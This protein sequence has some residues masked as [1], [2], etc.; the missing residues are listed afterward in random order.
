MSKKSER[1]TACQEKWHKDINLPLNESINWK[2]AY[3]TS[4]KCTKSTKLITFNFKLL[5][6]QLP[7]NSF[8]KKVGLRDDDKCTFCHKEIENLIHLFW[9]CKKTKEFW[10]S[11]FKWLKSCQ[12]SLSENN[13]LHINMALDLR[14]DSSK[15]K[16]QINFCCLIAKYY[17][18]LCRLKE[19]P[20]FLNNFLLYFKHIYEN[21]RK[22]CLYCP[23]EMGTLSAL[24]KSLDLSLQNLIKY[25][26]LSL[27]L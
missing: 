22:Q 19:H 25:T 16:L 23:K 10:D 5:H 15:H 8:L 18:W 6:R 21:N 13:Y 11:L 2:V 9:R 14:P 17:I 26:I 12:F 20:P 24:Y 3:Q 4:F 27:Q 1:P 7:T